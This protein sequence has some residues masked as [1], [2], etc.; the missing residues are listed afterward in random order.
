MKII[1]STNG[2]EI[3]VDDA[4][5]PQLCKLPWSFDKIGGVVYRG[6]SIAYIMSRVIMGL[7]F[8][9]KRVVDHI[10][11][12]QANNQRNN[13]RIC[14]QSQNRA[15]SRKQKE[16]SSKYK[17]VSYKKATKK[18]RAQIGING[19]KVHLGDFIDELDA[20]AAYDTAALE[21]FG[22]FALTNFEM[23]MA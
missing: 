5:Y 17:G 21:H 8:G 19:K 9:D 4:D 12:N 15:N 3:L 1:I 18:W 13:L 16:A 23:V 22:E 2:K 11:H 6:K 14:T 10:D 20:A 7:G